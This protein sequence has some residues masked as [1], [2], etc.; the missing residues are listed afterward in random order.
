[1]IHQ[2]AIKSLPQE[3]LWCETWCDDESK[4]KAKTIDLCNNPQTKEPKLEAAARIVPEWVDY[5]TEIRKL[6]QQI[7]KEKKSKKSSSKKGF[8]HDEL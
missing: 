4:K 1:M 7:E 3:W 5:D 6:I 8:K 2:V